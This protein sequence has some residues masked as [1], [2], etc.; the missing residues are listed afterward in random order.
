[1]INHCHVNTTTDGENIR[2]KIEK[3]RKRKEE[4]KTPT[5]TT[6]TT[7][8]TASTDENE[9]SNFQRLEFYV[10]KSEV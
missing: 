8:K 2:N 7:I 10:L 6:A 9:W 5:T 4:K 1:M 3:K